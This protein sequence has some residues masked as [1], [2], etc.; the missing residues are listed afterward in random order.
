MGLT[1]K[2]VSAEITRISQSAVGF[3]NETVERDTLLIHLYHTSKPF[4]GTKLQ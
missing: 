2:Q 3:I 4:T 1:S